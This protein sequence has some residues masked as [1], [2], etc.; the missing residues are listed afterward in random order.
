[1][2]EK[3]VRRARR[4]ER[5]QQMDVNWQLDADLTQIAMKYR[6]FAFNDEGAAAFRKFIASLLP[7]MP[8][9]QTK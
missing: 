4:A 7:A 8:K 3:T 5:E 9:T 2:L 6:G 1:M